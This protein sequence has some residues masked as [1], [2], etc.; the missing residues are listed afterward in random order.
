[1]GASASAEDVAGHVGSLGSAFQQYQTAIVENGLSGD[2]ILTLSEEE[3]IDTFKEFN[4]SSTV[5]RKKLVTE[6]KDFTRSAG[7]GT[8]T[9]QSPS[10]VDPPPPPVATLGQA[11]AA[12]PASHLALPRGQKYIFFSTHTWLKDELGRDTHLRVLEV[13]RGLQA[14]GKYTYLNIK[15]I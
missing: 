6:F 5:H 4:I 15:N 12:L 10:I 1:M 8:S 11:A 9:P 2:V 3:L 13:H 7:V 14:R